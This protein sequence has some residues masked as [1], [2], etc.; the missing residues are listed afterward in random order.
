MD[1]VGDV[2]GDTENLEQPRR[3]D[4]GVLVVHGIGD[5]KRGATLTQWADGLVAW[6]TAWQAR[7]NRSTVGSATVSDV[8]LNPPASVPPNLALDVSFVADDRDDHKWLFAEGW[9]AG[10]FEPPPFFKLWSWSFKSVPAT[11]AMQANAIVASARRRLNVATGANRI[12]EI[13]RIVVM[14]LLTVVVIA[15]S[16]VLLAILTVLLMLQYIASMLPFPA[17]RELVSR[18][19]LIAVG[20]IGDS[21]RLVESPTHAGAIKQPIVE[22][23]A[24]LRAQGCPRIVIIAHS[25]GA[26]ITYKVLEEVAEQPAELIEP[27]DA[28]VSVGSGLGKI[29]ALSHL[30]SERKFRE[31]R[32]ASLA[33]PVA[34]TVAAICIKYLA[35]QRRF[36]GLIG[37]GAIM[38]FGIALMLAVL[39][40]Q[41]ASWREP[42]PGV[43]SHP[44]PEESSPTSA[45]AK[46]RWPWLDRLSRPYRVVG[47]A[48]LP[49]IPIAITL[50]LAVT[51]SI[52]RQ[53]GLIPLFAAISVSAGFVGILYI[54][55]LDVPEISSD[56]ASSAR[57]WIDIYAS[58]D[59]VPAGSTRTT[60]EARPESW[61]V[62]NLGST[63]RDHTAYL[64][65]R[66]ECLTY[67]G[68]ELL[69][70]AQIPIQAE[71]MRFDNANYGF[72][73]RWR[74]GWRTFV[75]WMSLIAGVLL[76]LRTWSDSKDVVDSIYAFLAGPDGLIEWGPIY[77][78]T[79]S[80]Y[81]YVPEKLSPTVNEWVAA[82]GYIGIAL[83]LVNLGQ[84]LW[85]SW[86]NREA[87]Q[88]A[89][90]RLYETEL[91]P[92]QFRAMIVYLTIIIV[93]S[94]R[95]RWSLA[96]VSRL[97][98]TTWSSVLAVAATVGILLVAGKALPQYLS[99]SGIRRNIVGRNTTLVEGI[100]PFGHYLLSI[101]A[102]EE[103]I[104]AFRRAEDTF[105]RTVDSV[106]VLG[107]SRSDAVGGY[108]FANDR[109]AQQFRAAIAK[110]TPDAPLDRRQALIAA[111]ERHELVA[112]ENYLFAA[113]SEATVS[114][115]TLV[116]FAN[117][118]AATGTDIDRDEAFRLLD[119]AAKIDPSNGNLLSADVAHRYSI[120]AGDVNDA[121]AATVLQ[122]YLGT[123]LPSQRIELAF[124]LLVA[125]GP[126]ADVTEER[127]DIDQL[128]EVNY[129]A[130]NADLRVSLAKLP[131]KWEDDEADAFR[132]LAEKILG[133]KPLSASWTP[134][135]ATAASPTF[136][137][138][139]KI[140]AS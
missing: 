19:Q 39:F 76:P 127:A 128:L 50:G 94:I 84:A 26:A 133:R 78:L 67:V 3:Y 54:S 10:S 70:A 90:A 22:G 98:L 105:E 118:L 138:V 73:R 7:D 77:F 44:A 45:R 83:L 18:A 62:S 117:F 23:I 114:V 140:N 8:S 34:A 33:V 29:Q 71:A 51:W 5:Q 60:V 31:L 40:G 72:Q 88:E 124:N 36:I 126:L 17:L 125:K 43:D 93:A 92:L 42:K 37:M 112:R 52:Y 30:R 119:W 96:V 75:T 121:S 106:T 108:A 107:Q 66:D 24:W 89:T 80:F 1:D 53:Q 123:L 116:H 15:S 63:V 38:A 99:R 11:T 28:F 49:L 25:Q 79:F 134:Q 47:D 57:R 113:R 129:S 139:R 91:V 137:R 132:E 20:T 136:R 4:L 69:S 48:R 111:A 130:P 81:E 87:E 41:E 27:V 35:D 9:W 115:G 101:D 97:D 131:G 55:L 59:P 102:V 32:A 74:V 110:L 12:Y 16:P 58:K 85:A 86:D 109:R 82:I 122:Q 13:V 21:Q 64:A 95:P 120:G 2:S 135:S 14:V 104:K 68:I 56:L 61:R 100:I 6:V 103:A 46:Q 65:N